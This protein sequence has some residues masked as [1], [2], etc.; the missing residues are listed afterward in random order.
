MKS[1][2]DKYES[3]YHMLGISINGSSGVWANIFPKI[4]GNEYHTDVQI[5]DRRLFA[6]LGDVIDGGFIIDNRTADYDKLAKVAISG[7]M[8]KAHLPSRSKEEFTLDYK[9]KKVEPCAS[10]GDAGGFDSVSMDLYLQARHE[11]G[12]TIG[13]RH[14][15][16]VFWLHPDGKKSMTQIPDQA[17]RWQDDEKIERIFIE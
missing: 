10:Y 14:G 11:A 15:N 1:G 17:H 16:Q 6:Y 7:A 4:L 13:V 5:P 3:R 12:A 9:E 8:L 2:Y